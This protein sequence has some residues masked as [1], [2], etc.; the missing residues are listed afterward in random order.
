MGAEFTA[1][2]VIILPWARS[3]LTWGSAWSHAWIAR[4]HELLSM[5]KQ[6]VSKEHLPL[7]LLELGP[8]GLIDAGEFLNDAPT[9]TSSTYLTAA[10]SCSSS[11]LAL[12]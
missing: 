8:V 9:A 12:N 7:D 11:L 1:K 10:H 3:W 4:Q 5:V 6:V 2:T